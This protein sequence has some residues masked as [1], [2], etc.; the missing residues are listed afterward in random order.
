MVIFGVDPG[1]HATGYGIIQTAG[2]VPQ[3]IAAGDI[4]PPRQRTL[5]ERLEIIHVELSQ[6]LHRFPPDIV[7]LEKLFTHHAHVTTATLMAHARGVA[8]LVA[9]EQGVPL[10]EYLPRQVKQSI[11]G[12]GAASKAQ[13]ARMVGQWLPDADPHWS[14]DA[15]DALALA[16]VH[17]HIGR[18][19]ERLPLGAH[20]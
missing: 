19:R 1:L 18:Q 17:A 15:T 4:R 2:T 3:L 13:V 7:V 10:A 9:Q 16:L 12:S 8:C 20:A 14:S 6:L 11:T 5:G